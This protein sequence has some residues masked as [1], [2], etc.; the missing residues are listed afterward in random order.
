MPKE[1]IKKNVETSAAPAAIG[2]YSQGMVCGN[3]LF[4]SGQLPLEP[5]TGDFIEGGVE[6]KT[7]Q[8]IRNIKAVAEAAGAGLEQV[9]KTTIFL[10]DLNDFTTVNQVYGQYFGSV[11]PAR[12]TIQVAGL[13]KGSPIEM[14]AIVA[15]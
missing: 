6:T 4:I 15:L 8:V 9:V 3:L 14:K 12:S 11:P 13:P 10:S 5:E 2:P 1:S 7:H